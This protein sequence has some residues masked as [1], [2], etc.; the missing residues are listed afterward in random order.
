MTTTLRTALLAA[1]IAGCGGESIDAK[2]G[3]RDFGAPTWTPPPVCPP[4]SSAGGDVVASAAFGFRHGQLQPVQRAANLSVRLRD[5]VFVELRFAVP[6]PPP[7]SVS[8]TPSIAILQPVVASKSS[9]GF[10]L[11]A[12]WLASG[13]TATWSNVALQDWDVVVVR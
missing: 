5:D 9:D 2:P 11:A 7:Y 13:A 8:V 3:P 1:L 12:A 6:V 4:A 10:L